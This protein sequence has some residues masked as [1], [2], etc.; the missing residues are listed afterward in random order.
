MF[1]TSLDIGSLGI[2]RFGA[3]RFGG[4]YGWNNQKLLI[5]VSDFS[6]DILIYVYIYI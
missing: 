3:A 4:I 2:G 5:D 6:I 1:F